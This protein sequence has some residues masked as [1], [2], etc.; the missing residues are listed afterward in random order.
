MTSVPKER[1]TELSG[2]DLPKKEEKG[3]EAD[4]MTD[5][6]KILMDILRS[7]LRREEFDVDRILSMS[8]D[9]LSK[10]YKLASHH[11]LAHVVGKKIVKSGRVTSPTGILEA[12]TDAY[13]LASVI[14]IHQNIVFG[15][16][17]TAFENAGI[18]Y[19]PLKGSVLRKYY[20]DPSIRKSCDIDV[21]IKKD[22]LSEAVELLASENK[23]VIGRRL[24]K[25]ISL[26]SESG[27]H[28]E[29]HFGLIGY[30]NFKTADGEKSPDR[31]FENIWEEAIPD[32]SKHYRFD[33][34]PETFLVY[35]IAHMAKHFISGGCGIKP[36]MDLWIIERNFFF[37]RAEVQ[38][39][40]GNSGLY[41]F[42]KS[43]VDLSRKWF[44]GEDQKPETA[45]GDSD[46][47]LQSMEDYILSGGVYGSIGNNIA[48]SQAAKGG[49][50]GYIL[51]RI[52]LKYDILKLRYPILCKYPIL[53][54]AME[55]VRWISVIGQG[56]FRRLKN[57]A[58]KSMDTSAEKRDSVGKMLEDLGISVF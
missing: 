51:S 24:S 5:S 7:E 53:T 18:S 36:F 19:I 47:L 21:L 48:A 6:V 20:A 32:R 10:L 17:C 12:F 58:G 49:K 41:R 55:V 15:Q 43:S 38:K 9:E 13:D 31:L 40:L 14:F 52:F 16:I 11:E 33:M 42:Y 35:H 45:C 50:V 1:K 28:V 37:D 2:S 39:T 8:E 25:D 46:E 4:L 54:P 57:E 27:V 26:T 30:S 23:Y 3:L 22:Q 56:S 34:K 29:L 44:D